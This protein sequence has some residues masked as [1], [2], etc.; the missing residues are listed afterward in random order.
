MVMARTKAAQLWRG[1]CF[2][3][4]RQAGA[5]R[6]V[7]C[8]VVHAQT[9]KLHAS[10]SVGGHPAVGN[11]RKQASADGQHGTARCCHYG[12]EGRAP[13]ELDLFQ[14]WVRR[15]QQLSTW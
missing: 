13:F 14:P 9:L 5:F 12:S 2:L 4:W 1:C 10:W 6:G 3:L 15:G 11:G 8:K 7:R